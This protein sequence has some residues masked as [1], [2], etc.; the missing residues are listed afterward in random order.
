MSPESPTSG[1]VSLLSS[2]INVTF[3]NFIVRDISIINFWSVMCLISDFEDQ[4][5]PTSVTL[6][7][8]QV[9]NFFEEDELITAN[10]E[11]TNVGLI[12]DITGATNLFIANFTVANAQLRC[13]NF[14]N[15][16]IYQYRLIFG[17]VF[18]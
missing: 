5:S 7:N 14:Y 4:N 8:V 2:T 1:F 3:D 11:L 16:Q 17:K 15:F 18:T 10:E 12:F 13:K 9:E 6:T